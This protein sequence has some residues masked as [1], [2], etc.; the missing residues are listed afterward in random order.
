ML[1]GIKYTWYYVSQN[2]IIYILYNTRDNP[3]KN[4]SRLR[5]YTRWGVTFSKID[6]LAC[7]VFDLFC[8]SLNKITQM[9]LVLVK[10]FW[11][12]W[13]IYRVTHENLPIAISSLTDY[14][15]YTYYSKYITR[16]ANNI[17]VNSCYLYICRTRWYLN[18]Y[19]ISI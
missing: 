19:V 8:T 16:G 6:G 10:S 5:P 11:V 17:T 14:E 15:T 9:D 7:V 18:N 4:V 12:Y 1:D 3:S 2:V 13:K